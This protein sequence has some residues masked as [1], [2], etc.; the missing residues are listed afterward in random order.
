MHCNGFE[1]SKRAV[2]Q[3]HENSP[4][5]FHPFLLKLDDV[6]GAADEFS[7]DVGFLAASFRVGQRKHIGESFD[8]AV[9]PAEF[10]NTKSNRSKVTRTKRS[11]GKKLGFVF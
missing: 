5:F 3:L 7:E 1:T 8:S 9:R 11:D 4:I 10:V 2:L 6:S